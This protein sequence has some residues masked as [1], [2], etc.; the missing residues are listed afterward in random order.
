MGPRL[1]WD[2]AAA[3]RAAVDYVSRVDQ[4]RRRWR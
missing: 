2:E 4:D 3:E 1:G